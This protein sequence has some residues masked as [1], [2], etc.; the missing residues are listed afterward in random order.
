MKMWTLEDTFWELVLSFYYVGSEDQTQLGR[1][2]A[3]AF[4]H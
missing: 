3:S 2:L 1:F 4:T